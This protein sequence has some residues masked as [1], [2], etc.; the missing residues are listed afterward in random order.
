MITRADYMS[1]AATFAEYY[2][3]INADAGISYLHHPELERFR[4]VLAAGDEHLNSIPLRQWDAWGANPVT[5]S[6]LSRALKLRGDFLTE[7]GIVCCLK[8]AARDAVD[9]IR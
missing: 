8:Q 5:R 4:R 9:A 3:E 7:A 1:G 6:A 2:R